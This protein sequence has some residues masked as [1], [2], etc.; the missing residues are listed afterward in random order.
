MIGRYDYSFIV[1][2]GLF[3]TYLKMHDLFGKMKKKLRYR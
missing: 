3:R 1:R 2:N